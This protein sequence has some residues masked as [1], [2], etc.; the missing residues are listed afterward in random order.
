MAFNPIKETVGGKKAEAIRWTSKIIKQALDGID[1]GLP[2]AV[3]PFYEKN[4]KL[5]KPDLLYKRTPEEIQ[6]W[7]HCAKDIIYFANKYCKLMTP[8]GIQGITLRDYQEDYLR[9]LQKNRLSIM[10]SARQ[11]GKTTTSAIFML[12]YIIFNADKNA[13]VLGNKRDTAVEILKKTKDIFY[14]LP[15]FLKP[16]VRVW[17]EG[18][19]SLDNGCMIIAEATTARSGIGYTLH[20]VLLD[21]FAHIAP[22]IQEPFYKNIFPTI[23]AGRARLMITSTQN[24]LELFS[25]IYTAAVKGENEYAAFK[26]DWDQVPE[27]DPEKRIWYKRDEAWRQMQIGNL[28]SEDAFNEQFGT[29]FSAATNSLISKKVL[30]ENSKHTREFI[31]KDM[32]GC[33]PDNFFWAPDIEIYDLK[34]MYLVLTTDIAEGVGG[35]YTIQ[36]INQL[37]GASE[38]SSPITRCV[39]YYRTNT[40]SDKEC[41]DQLKEFYK[42]YLDNDKFLISLEYNLYGELWADHLKEP[43]I[44]NIIKY[45]ED[46]NFN[47]YKM[48]IRITKKTK[49]KMCKLFKT[50]YEKQYILNDDVKF[51]MELKNFAQ[52]TD[53]YKASF[54]HDDMVMA[55]AQLVL[56]QESLQF[57][58]MKEEFEANQG[59][60]NDKYV[61]FYDSI[62]QPMTGGSLYGEPQPMSWMRD[63]NLPPDYTSVGGR[64]FPNVKRL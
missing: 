15:Y 33:H 63:Q 20:C 60:T 12:W 30:T 58:Y 51:M 25:R 43:Y 34:N 56:A 52:S 40:L 37:I 29:E 10:L 27:W 6:E 48:G 5:L 38:D 46:D 44:G 42:L 24:G 41:C 11:S 50:Y 53:T 59:I 18:K 22:S 21:E 45:F 7:K 35:D 32:P 64:V 62:G 39:G 4:T 8:D 3:N 57:K 55:Q 31:V 19:I 47:R 1:K 2:L 9:H 17:N 16:G 23:S 13:M 61:N 54:G 14:E 28:G 26:V 36:V 49:N